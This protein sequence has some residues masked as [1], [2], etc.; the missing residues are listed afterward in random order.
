LRPK[1]WVLTLLAVVTVTG[2][3]S[4]G[5]S[6]GAEQATDPPRMGRTA[7]GV[8]GASIS[9]PEGWVLKREAYTYG[10]TYG[11][12]LWRQGGARGAPGGRC[13][14]RK[15]TP[16]SGSDPT[17]LLLAP[18]PAFSKT[19][20]CKAFENTPMQGFRKHPYEG[21]AWHTGLAPLGASKAS[22]ASEASV[23]NGK[24]SET[25]RRRGYRS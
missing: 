19:P 23:P 6:V 25:A 7:D 8:V 3:L 16:G 21:G 22:F 9:H 15:S 10:K 14:R 18:F 20:P 17:V 2:F 13:G 24:T 4:T 11:F 1:T 5:A 12:M